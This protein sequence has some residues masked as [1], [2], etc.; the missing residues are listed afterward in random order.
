[1]FH[2]KELALSVPMVTVRECLEHQLNK[3]RPTGWLREPRFSL[4]KCLGSNEV[5]GFFYF[6]IAGAFSQT[7]GGT[8]VTYR[9]LPDLATCSILLL[10]AIALISSMAGVL[11]G[12]DDGSFVLMTL[13]VNG[14]IWAY[15]LWGMSALAQ[16]FEESL[17]KTEK[18]AHPD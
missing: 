5:G 3:R 9:I 7:A 10:L 4:Y 17:K 18:Q 6:R 13:A 1:M 12:K 14:I 2:K 11:G 16:R 15:V 8:L